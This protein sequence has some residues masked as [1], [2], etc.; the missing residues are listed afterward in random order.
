MFLKFVLITVLLLTV[1]Q[2]QEEGLTASQKSAY[3][4][5]AH[6]TSRYLA[7]RTSPDPGIPCYIVIQ[8]AEN[9]YKA[10]LNLSDELEDDFHQEDSDLY[11]ADSKVWSKTVEDLKK[12]C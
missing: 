10:T 4:A 3:N 12:S 1:T 5:L 6:A 8:Y 11:Y 7:E 9:I 2:Q